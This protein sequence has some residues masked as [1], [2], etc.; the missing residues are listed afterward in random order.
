MA[1]FRLPCALSYAAA[2]RAGTHDRF[3][4]TALP[5][6]GRAPEDNLYK[7][8]FQDRYAL[9][10]AEVGQG[11]GDYLPDFNGANGKVFKWVAPLNGVRQGRFEP[12]IFLVTPKRLRV[13]DIGLDYQ[14]GK[15]TVLK[16]EGAF[17][18]YD[19]NLF[20]SKDKRESAGIASKWQLLR[21]DTI[22]IAE[23][24]W[25]MN[26]EAGMEWVQ[27]SFKP[28]ERLR[29]VEFT[30]DWGLPLQYNVLSDETILTAELNIKKQEQFLGYKFASYE[31]SDGFLGIR[32]GLEV[33]QDLNGWIFRNNITHSQVKSMNDKGYFFRPNLQL[34][35]ELKSWKM[36][37]LEFQ[38][39][40]ERNSIQNIRTDSMQLQSFSFQTLQATLKSNVTLPNRWTLN[41]I[42]RQNSYPFGK[43]LLP[44]DNSNSVQITADLMRN[45]KHQ[46]HTSAIYRNLQVVSSVIPSLQSD[47]S[48]LS[49]FE[50][51]VNE[52]QGFLNGEVLYET[53]AGQ[54]QKRDLTYIEVPAGQGE[55]TWNDYNADGIQ[56]LNE[57][58]IAVFR[59]QAKY[60][61][62]FT[63]T[64]EFVKANYNSFNYTL[65]LV[66]R[67]LLYGKDLK[68]FKKVI[69]KVQFQSSLQLQKKQLSEGALLL[70]PWS[71]GLK[72]TGLISL[73]AH[74]V[75][76]LAY[77][78]SSNVW[79][80]DLIHSKN[81][82]KALLA[83]GYE[84]RIMEDLSLRTRWSIGR[85]FS[86]ELL[87]RA[88]SNKLQN[89]AKSF[90]N[91]NYSIQQFSA[92]P[93]LSY[94]M[95]SNFRALVSYKWQHKQNLEGLEE[96]VDLG[97]ANSELKYNLL[98]NMSLQS[99]FTVT[100]IR[101]SSVGGSVSG[102]S[103]SSY[104]M[105]EGLLPGKNFLWGL[106]L[107]KRLSNNLE[108]TMQYEGRKPGT[109][110]MVHVGRAG[111]KALL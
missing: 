10:F 101:F 30:R 11:K 28:L 4:S 20:S 21:M 7:T 39:Q 29:N 105:L 90:S 98:Q 93:K 47:K 25:Q 22:R 46:F 76:S 35:K 57:F 45:E 9:S 50:Y 59:D 3:W 8:V 38:Y 32:N 1:L 83:Y 103:P 65:Q 52:W 48:L 16:G 109:A 95:G 13:M 6:R 107:T 44:S 75:N 86:S 17:S 53:G 14:L 42:N 54:E 23:K 60:I 19:Q 102:N 104:I 15:H 43:K 73:N 81:S 27:A 36:H 72:D 31:R 40:L 85:S 41:F 37:Q 96:K 69:S 78:R 33:Q 89:S 12:A 62:I 67:A 94:T 106:D 51:K 56:Q 70:T 49:R 91:R 24:Q 61:R 58:E 87:M 82:N 88:G 64:N 68:G 18:Y 66:P 99:K 80:F 97:S 34:L 84:S 79:G 74:Q 5:D 77:N 108:L 55:F 71:G 110:R 92:E 63:P 100:D 111:L 2:I 26:A